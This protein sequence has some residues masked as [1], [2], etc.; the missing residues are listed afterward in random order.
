MTN[1]IPLTVSQL[2]DIKST[3]EFNKRMI[4]SVLKEYADNTNCDEWLFEDEQ[5]GQVINNVFYDS[6]MRFAVD[7]IEEYGY[8]NILKAYYK[9]IESRE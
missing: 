8:E 3:L 2:C 4:Y 5:S 9:I 7:P 6:T 1:H